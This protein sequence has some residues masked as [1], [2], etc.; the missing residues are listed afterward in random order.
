MWDLGR[1]LLGSTVFSR[2]CWLAFLVFYS[3]KNIFGW[4]GWTTFATGIKLGWNGWKSIGSDRCCLRGPFKVSRAIL[5]LSLNLSTLRSLV[6]TIPRN[7]HVS[8]E[9][10]WKSVL[11]GNLNRFNLNRSRLNRLILIE[12]DLRVYCLTPETSLFI[13]DGDSSGV[14]GLKET[15]TS[16]VKP[17]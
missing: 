1:V 6:M 7:Y 2:L 5:S 3:E 16:T 14:N 4:F 10:G 11:F 8:T 12:H 13:N 9:N 17:I 15:S